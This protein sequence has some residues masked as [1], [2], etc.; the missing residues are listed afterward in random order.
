[1]QD[2]FQVIGGADGCRKL[3][4]TFYQRV[5]KDPVL[6]PLFPGKSLRCAI[7]GLSEFLAHFLGGSSDYAQNRWSLSLPDAHMRFRIGTRERD[8]WMKN[9]RAVLKDVDPQL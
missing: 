5:A 6:Q 8:A 1:M 7:E 4:E 2:L 3:S 9:M